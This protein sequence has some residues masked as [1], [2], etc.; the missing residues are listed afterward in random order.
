MD[1]DKMFVDILKDTDDEKGSAYDFIATKYNEFSKY[2]L[3][4]IILECLYAIYRAGREITG[5]EQAILREIGENLAERWYLD[6]EEDNND[7]GI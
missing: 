3:K 4:E 2:E 5:G 7:E 1:Y 6:E